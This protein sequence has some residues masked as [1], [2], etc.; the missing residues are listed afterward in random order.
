MNILIADDNAT[1]LKLLRVTLEAEGH[2]VFA[3]GDGVEAML[4]LEHQ[5]IAAVIS[6]ILMPRM[7][8]YRLCY[9]VRKSRTS[10][11]LPFI[12]Y[13]ST[14]TTPS[15]EKLAMQMG[16]DSFL[17]KP[18]PTDK[19]LWALRE[20]MDCP[21]RPQPA[22]AASAGDVELMKDYSERLVNKLEER[23]C[24]LQAACEKLFLLN[25][26]VCNRSAQLEQ[27]QEA[28]KKANNELERRVRERTAELEAVNAELETFNHSAAHDLRAPLRGIDGFSA[29]L[30]EDC[31]AHLSADGKHYL[32]RILQNTARMK[33]IIDSLLELSRINRCEM[34]LTAIDLGEVARAILEELQEAEPGRKVEIRV[35]PNVVT[36]GDERLLR[37]ALENLLDN[38][39]KFTAKKGNPCIEF[40]VQSETAETVY[41]VRDNG[42]GFNMAHTRHLFGPFQRLHSADEFPG[43]GAGLATVQRII[44]RHG[45]RI[46]GEGKPG[47]GAA[48]Y[49]TLRQ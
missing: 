12:F 41:F 45:G 1:N 40:G 13:T 43:T 6:D 16:A 10:H 3:A 20:A 48:F 7:D 49:F 11:D 33:E 2:N 9:E 4:V 39:W 35:A 8:G 24:E 47:E 5:K 29:A 25:Q 18:A 46:W 42:A 14:Y 21:H 32:Q 26:T 27:A 15:D 17:R 22:R 34:K 23:N 44:A 38:S 19:I 30:L 31:A 37:S 36:Q 28:L